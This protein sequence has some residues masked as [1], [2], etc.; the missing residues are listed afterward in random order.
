MKIKQQFIDLHK[1]SK[2][3]RKNGRMRAKCDKWL[4][5]IPFLCYLT[6]LLISAEGAVYGGY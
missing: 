6:I 3:L 2:N 4:V 1:D 5:H